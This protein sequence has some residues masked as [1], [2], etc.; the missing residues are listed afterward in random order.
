MLLRS[1]STVQLKTRV[2]RAMK[3]K[4]Y[5]MTLL[6]G[7]GLSSANTNSSAPTAQQQQLEQEDRKR[8]E[9]QLYFRKDSDERK[10][11]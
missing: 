6:I 2:D 11:V 4:A 9:Q 5:L 10:L 7:A 1:N 8:A 3:K